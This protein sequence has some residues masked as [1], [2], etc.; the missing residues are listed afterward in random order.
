MKILQGQCEKVSTDVEDPKAIK[1]IAKEMAKLCQEPIGRY[2]NGLALAHCQVDHDDPKRF[3]V[4]QDGRVVINPVIIKKEGKCYF[5]EG[6]LSFPYG[7]MSK[8]K[9]YSKITVEYLNVKGKR[10]TN[11]Y[12]DLEAFIFQHEIQHFNA[13]SI[14][15]KG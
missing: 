4:Y 6:C 2:R 12:E 9:R 8:V 7:V 10:M 13:K 3:F 5:S 1:D 14:Y 15:D 11:D